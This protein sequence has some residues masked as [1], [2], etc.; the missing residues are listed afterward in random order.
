MAMTVLH[1][2]PPLGKPR[3]TLLRAAALLFAL[4]TLS[5]SEKGIL[6]SVASS[7]TPTIDGKKV[8]YTMHFI[9]NRSP[10]R[11]FSY[12]ENDNLLVVIECYDYLIHV[13]DSMKMKFAAPVKAIDV[14]NVST[15]IVLSGQKSQILVHLKEEMHSEVGCSGDTLQLVLWKDLGSGKTGKGKNRKVPVVPLVILFLCAALS[16]FTLIQLSES[17]HSSASQP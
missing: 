3:F 4:V 1:T 6:L 12:P 7:E 13:Q 11:Y 14:K 17:I 2:F 10:K 8:S 5:W 9:F 16:V 15:S